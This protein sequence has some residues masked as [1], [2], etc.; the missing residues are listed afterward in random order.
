M[1]RGPGRVEKM[2]VLG[3]LCWP[4]LCGWVGGCQN[5]LE[6]ETRGPCGHGVGDATPFGAPLPEK[7]DIYIFEAHQTFT[8]ILHV[9]S[10]YLQSVL[11]LKIT[12]LHKIIVFALDLFIT[13]ASLYRNVRPHVQAPQIIECHL[14]AK[15][16]ECNCIFLEL[17]PKNAAYV[18]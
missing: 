15:L 16:S 17:K 5:G 7:M 6:E 13:C 9:I 18:D 14:E 12:N 4:V 1:P 11:Y 2:Q 10:G 3:C 8:V